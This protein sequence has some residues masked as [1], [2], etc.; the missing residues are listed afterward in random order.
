MFEIEGAA[1]SWFLYENFGDLD[2]L[3][4][5]FCV[6]FV[7]VLRRSNR[8]KMLENRTQNVDEPVVDYFYDK[9]GMCRSLEWTFS[10]TRDVVL[11]GLLSK[12]QVYWT[13]SHF[14]PRLGTVTRQEQSEIQ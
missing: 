3:V 4:A 12:D 14:F 8:W 11:E 9:A 6:A 10:E 2:E 7:R 13:S 1:R 5:K